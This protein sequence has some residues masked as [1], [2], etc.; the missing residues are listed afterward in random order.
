M[1]MYVFP[2]YYYAS[3]SI[4]QSVMSLLLDAGAHCSESDDAELL[5]K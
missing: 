3:R 1:I 2:I 5:L 4:K